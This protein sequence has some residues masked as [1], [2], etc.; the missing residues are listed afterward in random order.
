METLYTQSLE[1]IREA[2]SKLS[3]AITPPGRDILNQMHDK[4]IETFNNEI[5]AKGVG[6]FSDLLAGYQFMLAR[7]GHSQYR[8]AGALFDD[9]SNL[10]LKLFIEASNY[11]GAGSAKGV[12]AVPRIRGEKVLV[13][14]P[15]KNFYETLKIILGVEFHVRLS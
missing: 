11:K 9:F 4:V 14:K 7:L 3:D 2:K 10:N 8:I 13:V 12:S 5:L 1:K 6:E 15:E